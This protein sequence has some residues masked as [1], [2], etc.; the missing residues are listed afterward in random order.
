MDDFQCAVGL[1]CWMSGAC[2]TNRART[3]HDHN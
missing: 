1:Q 2:R 3:V